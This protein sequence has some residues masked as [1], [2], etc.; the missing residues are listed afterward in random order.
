MQTKQPL[1]EDF[2][3][4]AAH[5]FNNGADGYSKEELKLILGAY[6][7][8]MEEI[9]SIMNAPELLPETA[10]QRCREKIGDYGPASG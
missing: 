4:E 1:F 7:E 8:R 6:Y 9:Y 5:I 3:G 10:L 2:R